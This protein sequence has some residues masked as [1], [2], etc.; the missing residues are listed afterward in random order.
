MI[1]KSPEV[2]PK[3]FI[4]RS[5]SPEKDIPAQ[6][7]REQRLSAL[8]QIDWE[9]TRMF[10][11]Y[12]I[13][14][15]SNQLSVS[16][17][18]LDPEEYVIKV[19]G[20]TWDE[21]I[22]IAREDQSDIDSLRSWSGSGP[23]P[24]ETY[25]EIVCGNPAEITTCFRYALRDIFKNDDGI[26]SLIVYAN[27]EHDKRGDIALGFPETSKMK[28]WEIG[29]RTGQKTIHQ[30]MPIGITMMGDELHIPIDSQKETIWV[31]GL[32][33]SGVEKA[34]FPRG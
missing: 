14:G 13:T 34:T 26:L 1:D 28:D 20:K 15:Q 19:S 16:R 9:T 18:L 2:S 6:L 24:K 17:S 11:S 5:F 27:L 23:S 8:G 22:R 10:Q 32:S 31:V 33:G 4:H 21:L 7:V 3:T 30:R 12:E 25:L 29:I